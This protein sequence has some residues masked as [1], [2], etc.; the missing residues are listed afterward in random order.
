MDPG[1]TQTDVYL[2]RN[3]VSLLRTI[4]RSDGTACPTTR[5]WGGSRGCCAPE[6]P[7]S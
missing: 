6:S 7:S 4:P 1:G 3:V 5:R 2:M